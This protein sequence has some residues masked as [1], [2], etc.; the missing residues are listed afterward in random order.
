MKKT[1]IYIGIVCLLSNLAVAQV[2]RTKAPEPGP[3]PEIKI[4]KPAF[5]ELKNGLKVYVVEN[6]KLPRIAFSL[7]L[8]RE[9]ILEG[10]NAGYVSMTG[11]MLMSGT[12]NRTKAV[13]D[14]EIDFIGASI[15]T[16]SSGVNASSLTRHQDKLLELMADVLYNPS[17]PVEELDKLK[18]QTL[19]GL[20]QSKE[21]PG[22]I[23]GNVR[24][25]LVYGADHPYGELNTEETVEKITVEDCKAYYDKFFKPNIGYLAIVGDI[26]LKDAKKLVKKYFSEWERGDVPK[27]TYDVPQEPAKTYVAM[28]DRAASVQS[29]IN[30][31]YPVP[32]KIG[33]ADVIKARVLNQI[34]GAGFSSRLMQNLREDKAFTYGARSSLS[35]DDLVGSFTA[36][37]SVRNEV[38]DSAVFEFMYELNKIAK[39]EVT[40]AELKSA[41]AS[42]MG[43]FGRSLESPQTVAR[44][45][46]NS[47][48]YNLPENY[49]N[50]YLKRL[51]AVT[52]ADVREMAV[53]YIR[54][55]NAHIVVVGK[56]KEV[57]AKLSQFGEVKYFD[58]YGKGYVPSAESMLPDG[59]TAEKVITGYV[60]A[61]G[62]ADKINDIENVEMKYKASV[63]GRDMVI[64]QIMTNDLKSK[65]SIDMG[66]MIVMESVTDGTEAK[67]SQMGQAAPLDDQTK[68]EQILTSGL[69]SELKLQ[70]LGATLKLV[71][72]EQLN[73]KEHYVMEVTLSKGS[74]YTLYFDATTGLKSRFSKSIETP[75]GNVVQVID[76]ANYRD[77]NGVK[78]A[79]LMIQKL[80]Q[81]NVNME[82][83]SV[84]VNVDIPT[85]TFKVN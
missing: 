66:G 8:D 23:A 47:A 41:K 6:H 14:K 25:K 16:S 34:L 55:E 51:D 11:Q 57:S 83:T 49:Y 81:Q 27:D 65:M 3:A 43:R 4:A 28:V 72:I 85:E 42:I 40:E 33:S 84:K 46:I 1:L 39:E 71:G 5:F 63:M 9:P 35:S 64:T 60:T 82:V 2:D 68:E 48:V 19:S 58:T 15:S 76:Y 38:T 24:S 69:F 79:H 13:L 74:V 22:A 36:S 75:Q 77:V 21:D 80:G 62:G 12:K 18:K 31:S 17:F 45:A 73:D 52:I 61:I 10:E 26:T 44:F 7:S 54:P 59:L 67:V 53:K 29:M 37:A 78:L 50:D 56:A 32:L 30:I 70:N 20:A